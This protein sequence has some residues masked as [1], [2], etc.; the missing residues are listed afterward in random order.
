VLP[1]GIRQ[2]VYRCSGGQAA[3]FSICLRI[4]LSEYL[5]GRLGLNGLLLLDAV[6]EPIDPENR[7]VAA[8]ALAAYGPPQTLIFSYFPVDGLDANVITVP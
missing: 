5:A 3:L 2:P 1:D 8:Q 4:A 6:F 7:D